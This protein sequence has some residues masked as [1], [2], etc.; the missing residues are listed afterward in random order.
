MH[1]YAQMNAPVSPVDYTQIC[2]SCRQ[3]N[4][5]GVCVCA[6]EVRVLAAGLLCCLRIAF[7]DAYEH[8]A[9]HII[10]KER[11]KDEERKRRRRQSRQAFDELCTICKHNFDSG[12]A[13]CGIVGLVW[14]YCRILDK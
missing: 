1:M 9:Q 8:P 4:S 7:V 5:E 11:R 14:Q 6:R 3:L 13:C 12:I 10:I 2:F